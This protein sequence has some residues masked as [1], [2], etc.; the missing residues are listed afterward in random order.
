MK[1]FSELF[2][3]VICETT[4]SFS[5]AIK[6]ID[7]YGERRLMIGGL[8]QSRSR[9]NSPYWGR[10]ASYSFPKKKNPSVL[11]LGL[12]GGTIARL[13]AK[14]LR[15]KIMVGVEIDSVIIELGKK[16]FGLDKIDNLKVIEG[17]AKGFIMKNSETFDYIVVD[18]FKGGVFP[19][20]LESQFFLRRLKGALTAEGVLVFNR[21]FRISKPERRLKFL[22][23]LEQFFGQ[24]HE[25]VIEGPSDA[26]N[27]LYWILPN[28][29]VPS[30]V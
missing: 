2:P 7:I 29:P 6:V 9:I 23:V 15:P 5:G 22:R 16:Y 14:K 10:L 20:P 1:L 30:P 11:I 28:P 19:K 21:I 27:Y 13:L 24:A 3:T 25:E 18:T 12:G 8:V 26:K 17:D 4:S